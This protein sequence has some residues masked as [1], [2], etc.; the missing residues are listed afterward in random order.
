MI[1]KIKIYEHMKKVLFILGLTLLTF[2]CKKED[3]QPNEPTPTEDCSCG[4][5]TKQTHTIDGVLRSVYVE[6]Y[7][8]GN[9]YIIWYP[10]QAQQNATPFYIGYTWCDS[11]G[12]TW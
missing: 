9:E 12:N 7:C 8:S 1:Y 4:I 3:I 11:N 6:N 2:S 5:I 10:T